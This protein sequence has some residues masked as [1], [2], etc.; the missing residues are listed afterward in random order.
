MSKNAPDEDG[1]R[2]TNNANSNSTRILRENS[3]IEP[4]VRNPFVHN[5]VLTKYD[6]VKVSLYSTHETKTSDKQSL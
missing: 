6:K 4:V 1:N 3:F 2:G 5:L